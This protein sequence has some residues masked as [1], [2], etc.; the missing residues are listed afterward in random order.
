MLRTSGRFPGKDVGS[1]PVLVWRRKHGGSEWGETEFNSRRLSHM[2]EVIWM[3]PNPD[4]LSLG[5]EPPPGDSSIGSP[6]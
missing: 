3:G 1:E 5:P 2:N 6:S 4:F